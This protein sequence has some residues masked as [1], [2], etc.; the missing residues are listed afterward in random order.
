MTV[1][2]GVRE[3]TV[4]G[5]CVSAL[6]VYNMYNRRTHSVPIPARCNKAIFNYEL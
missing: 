1:L 3:R 4:H 6:R 2:Q 5:H